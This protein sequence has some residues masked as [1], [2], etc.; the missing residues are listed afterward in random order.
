M[1]GFGLPILEALANNCPV[2]ASNIPVFHEIAGDNIY[3]FNIEEKD[4]L[5]KLMR[6]IYEG[7]FNLSWKTEKAK[8]TTLKYSFKKMAE[9]TLKIYE[10]CSRL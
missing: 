10:N 4:A 8:E 3:Y 9:E 5:Y 2:L 1:E 7:T 6:K